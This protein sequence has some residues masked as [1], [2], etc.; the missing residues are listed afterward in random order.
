MYVFLLM[1]YTLLSDV[2]CGVLL[3]SAILSQHLPVDAL[4]MVANFISPL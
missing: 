4:K 1:E 3:I 2:G